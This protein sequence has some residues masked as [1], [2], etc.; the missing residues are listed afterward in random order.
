MRLGPHTVTIRRATTTEDAYGNPTRNWATA[1]ATVV[2][3][4]SVQPVEGD[5]QTVGRDTVVSR[6]RLFAPDGTDLLAS[7][8]VEHGGQTYEVD[9]EV[10][11]WDF[12]PMSHLS[13]LLRRGY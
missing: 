2:P 5:E 1:T 7:D 9:S 13:A 10:G 12:P 11:R 6:W 4:C 3:G 8:R